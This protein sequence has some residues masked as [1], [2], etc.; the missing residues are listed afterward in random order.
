MTLTE[1]LYRRVI[2]PVDA[3]AC[4]EWTGYRNPK[5]YGMIRVGHRMELTHRVAY[6]LAHGEFDP[7]LR[8][9]HACDNP[10][11]V[12]PDH[13]WI[14]TDADN[15]KD[16][17]AKGRTGTRPTGTEHHRSRLTADAVR[18]IRQS[19]MSLRELSH[20]LGVSRAAISHVRAGRCW[21]HVA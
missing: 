13:L 15:V 1:R 19:D 16:R 20:L 21:R 7:A 2:V 6:R 9:C 18:L 10:G 8:V 17:D 5:G 11:C 3:S 4:W 14:G 12:R